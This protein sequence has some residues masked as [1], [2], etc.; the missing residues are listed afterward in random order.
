[1]AIGI[2]GI[3]ER[4]D[5]GDRGRWGRGHRHWPSTLKLTVRPDGPTMH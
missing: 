4:A 3:G 1:M 5:P 2:I